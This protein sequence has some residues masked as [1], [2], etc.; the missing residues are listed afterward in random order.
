MTD[1]ARMER[2]LVSALRVDR[3]PVAIAFRDAPPPGVTKFEGVEPSGCSFWRLAAA[4][5]AFYTEP[6][7]HYNCA[8]GS[9][10]HGIT[11]PPDREQ[12]LGQTLTLMSEIGYIR[13]E[14][15]P[16]VPRVPS[17]PAAVVYAPL[18]ETPIEPDV[19]LVAGAPSALMV[20]H[21]AA[22]R[23]GTTL[24]PLLGRPTCMAIPATLAGGMASS[25]GC[26]GN[27]VYT[28]IA[29]EEFY[30]VMSA[31]DAPAI[32][33]QLE[34]VTSANATLLDYHRARR[35]ALANNEIARA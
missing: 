2:Q 34:T 10:T 18:A 32:A 33:A 24:Q 29:D 12:E 8:I 23:A 26:I 5:A 20:L 22:L 13:M 1:Y 35:A 11:L 4:G 19:I 25:L 16:G 7:D 6:S 31:K 21:E 17:P 3:R 15:V 30:T 27:R 9:Y 14:E 28:A